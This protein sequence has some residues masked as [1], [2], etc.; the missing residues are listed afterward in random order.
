MSVSYSI[1]IFFPIDKG[2][3]ILKTAWILNY[4]IVLSKEIS[5]IVIR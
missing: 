3:G 4:Q 1:C 2:Q 5:L